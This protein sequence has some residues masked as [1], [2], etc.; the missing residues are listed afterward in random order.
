MLAVAITSGILARWMREGWE[1]QNDLTAA[2]AAR[3]HRL[4]VIEESGRALENLSTDEAL[5][6]CANQIIALGFEAATVQY[7][8]G[9]RPH[10]AVGRCEIV[11]EA[12]TTKPTATEGLVTTW[13]DAERVRVHSASIL[14]R[15]SGAVVTGWSPEPVDEDQAQALATLVAHTSNEIEASSLL[16]R[17][18]HSAAHDPLTGL[19]NRGRFDRQLAVECRKSGRLIVAFVDLDHFKEINDRQ[20]HLVGDQALT[21]IARRLEGIVGPNGLIA[22]YG[23]DEF[24]ILLPGADLEEGRRVAQAMLD[25]T[26]DPIAVKQTMLTLGLSIGIAA[27]A[28]PRTGTDL[29]RAADQA[30]YQVKTAGRA[31]IIAVDVDQASPRVTPTSA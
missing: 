30:A 25:T 13:T 6:V 24:V 14:E 20:G 10:V 2:I 19:A 22:R 1:I 9:D 11:A 29:V 17:L 12:G 21:A 5:E 31:R 23:G 4:A 18:R 15:H 8:D 16:E 7:P 26:R 27:S 28:T 3:E